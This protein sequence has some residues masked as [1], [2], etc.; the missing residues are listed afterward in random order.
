MSLHD[1]LTFR[2]LPA[3]WG[4]VDKAYDEAEAYYS[5]SGEALE[6][7]LL[8]IRLEH[9]RNA[10]ERELLELD[11]RYG[12]ISA[13]DAA[14]RRVT[15]AHSEGIERELALLDVEHQFGDLSDLAYEKQRA[16]L[17]NEPWIGIVNSGFDP[18]QGI[19]GVFFEF[20]WNPQWI[21]FLRQ[22]GYI[23]HTDDQV[24][25]DWF[26]DV[27]RSHAQVNDPVPFSIARDT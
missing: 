21:E 11:A 26:T 17:K 6:R 10:L 1:W 14:I 3:S 9:D 22:H 24:I 25:D 5:L 8:H 7:R 15:M 16:A 27:C 18:S 12:H 4:L 19:D 23:G 13:Y 20:D 2:F